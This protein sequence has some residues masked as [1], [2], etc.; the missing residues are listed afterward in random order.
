M[1]TGQKHVLHMAT[2]DFWCH[3]D[4][5]E[6]H[7]LVPSVT[8]SIELPCDGEIVPERARDCRTLSFPESSYMFF[9]Y[10]AYTYIICNILYKRK[11]Q[12]YLLLSA[13]FVASLRVWLY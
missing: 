7:Q 4:L 5:C 10:T 1:V 3:C 6:A 9:M 8:E 13:V 12:M 2:L 11:I